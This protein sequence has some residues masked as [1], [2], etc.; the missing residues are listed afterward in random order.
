[1]LTPMAVVDQW[2]A[3]EQSLPDSWESARLRLIVSDR[4]RA[5]R[6]AALLGPANP[7][8]YG[9]FVSFGV[10]R[11]GSGPSPNLVR[12]LLAR[13]DAEKIDGTLDAVAVEETAAAAA[14]PATGLPWQWQQLL[15]ELPEDWSDLYAEAELRSS[16]YLER[17]ALLLAPMNPS[18]VRDR[19]AFR[20]RA[21]RS[22]GYG[23][24]PEMTRR[25]FERLEAENIRGSVRI[26][27][28]LSDTKPVYTQG[29][30]WYV[31]GGPV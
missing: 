29:P 8:R 20:F 19:T 1:M 21:A 3:I 4:S 9:S 13:L 23:A 15:D 22:F 18:R 7:G 10:A 12:R 16:D 26:L 24:S 2:R 30:V 25:C 6:A 5:E 11:R 31:G 28:A 27:W 14:A 17:A